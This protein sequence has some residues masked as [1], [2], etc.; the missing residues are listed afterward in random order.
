MYGEIV[1]EG[2][3]DGDWR[4]ILRTI[5]QRIRRACHQHPWFIDVLGGRPHLGP[6]ALTM[7]E[8]SLAALNEVAG[9]D[10]IDVGMRA[11]GTVNAYVIGAVR[12]ESSDLKSG[13]NKAEWQNVWW[14][15]LDRVIATGRFPMLAKVVRDASHP[16]PDIVFDKGLE[17]VLD[18]LAAQL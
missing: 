5:A 10:D 9:F 4:D 8:A 11:M 16:T 14:P 18:G 17:T 13:M 15:Y 7:L 3:I 6:N 1:S 12:N 2:P